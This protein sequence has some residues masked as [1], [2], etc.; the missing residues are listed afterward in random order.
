MARA[1]YFFDGVKDTGS[2]VPVNNPN[3]T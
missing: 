3:R 2:Y 1:K